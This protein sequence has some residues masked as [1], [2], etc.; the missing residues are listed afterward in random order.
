MGKNFKKSQIPNPGLEALE[1][2]LRLRPWA[3]SRASGCKINASAN[4]LVLGWRIFQFFPFLGSV[5]SHSQ[6]IIDRK[7]VRGVAIVGSV[8]VG[9]RHDALLSGKS[10]R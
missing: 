9:A 8:D 5:L 10:E 7:M 3:I 6:H 4:F 1:V 2:A